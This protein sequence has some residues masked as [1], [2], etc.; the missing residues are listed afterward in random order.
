MSKVHNRVK[1]NI[2]DWIKKHLKPLASENKLVASPDHLPVAAVEQLL[3]L[4]VVWD[5]LRE[6]T[7][8]AASYGVGVKDLSAGMVIFLVT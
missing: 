1:D 7:S 6:F 4:D 3:Q 5:L 2:K 8:A